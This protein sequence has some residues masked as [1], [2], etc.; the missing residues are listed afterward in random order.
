MGITNELRE[1]THI[2]INNGKERFRGPF[3]ECWTYIHKHQG[4]SVNFACKYGGW[5]IIKEANEK[6]ENG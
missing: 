5:T 4:Q 3:G 1:S 2:V 6:R